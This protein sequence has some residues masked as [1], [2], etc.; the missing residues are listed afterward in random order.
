[1]L[2]LASQFQPG[3]GANVDIEDEKVILALSADDSYLYFTAT[4]NG[5]SYGE[6]CR[7]DVA[8]TTVD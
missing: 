5:D 6:I 4:N 7:L 1:M 3:T 8:A 2:Y